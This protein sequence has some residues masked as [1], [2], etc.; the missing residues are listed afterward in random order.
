LIELA[1]SKKILFPNFLIISN[2]MITLRNLGLQNRNPLNLRYQPR[3]RYRGLHPTQPCVKGF[4]NFLTFD[5][6]YRAAIIE[7][8]RLIRHY[9]R[10]TVVQMIRCLTTL[11]HHQFTLYVACICGRSR[12]SAFETLCVEG[13][14]IGRLVAAMAQQ[15][16]G[17]HPTPEYID[18]LR[19]QFGSF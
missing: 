3:H 10:T 9:P 6:G 5:H 8:V 14:Q 19:K 17:L 11:P 15:E 7:M 12:L 13:P 16:T 2:I 4:C 18:H 1:F